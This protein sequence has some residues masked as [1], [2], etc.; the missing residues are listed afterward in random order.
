MYLRQL[1]GL[2][3]RTI[4][5][6]LQ[7]QQAS[8]LLDRE[9]KVATAPNERQSS[10]VIVVIAALN[11]YPI[12]GREQTDVLVVPDHRGCRLIASASSPILRAIRPW[13]GSRS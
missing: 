13:S 5:V 6:L 4:A 3:A 12:R 9:I 2:E 11:A 1:T 8:N 10:H 7:L